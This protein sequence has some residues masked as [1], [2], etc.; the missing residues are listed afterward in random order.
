V[1][2]SITL[3]KV[4]LPHRLNAHELLVP[5][6]A[7]ARLSRSGFQLA[8]RYIA[9]KATKGVVKP[10]PQMTVLICA[11]LAVATV[12]CAWPEDATDAALRPD[13]VIVVRP[14]DPQGEEFRQVIADTMRI[15]LESR[16]LS[17]ALSQKQDGPA[18]GGPLEQARASNAPVAI[19]C[20]YSLTRNEI[21]VSMGWY[22]TRAGSLAA[23]AQARGRIGLRLDTAVLEALDSILTASKERVAELAAARKK[24]NP[25][26]S[27]AERKAGSGEAGSGLPEPAAQSGEA[28]RTDRLTGAGSLAAA[29]KPTTQLLL[30]GGFAPFIP[31]GAASYYFTVGYLPSLLV[32]LM[33]DTAAGRVGIGL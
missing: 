19:D 17:V 14:R 10:G 21:A 27:V 22:E 7:V 13:V 2:G 32:S 24:M 25:A 15:Q 16:G 12:Q 18:G 11:L 33:F 9:Q 28:Q 1:W 31:S 30:V 26:A 20:S 6:D 8:T 5:R 29:R 23:R 3:E 4:A